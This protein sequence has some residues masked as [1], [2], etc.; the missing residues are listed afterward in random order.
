M[1]LAHGGPTGSP[2]APHLHPDVIAV[3][4]LV[5]GAYWLALTRLRPA[6]EPACTTR[7]ARL[8]VPGHSVRVLRVAGARRGRGLPVRRP[9]G[10]A[11]D[12]QP[13]PAP[14][15]HPGHTTVAVASRARPGDARLPSAGAPLGRGHVV[16]RGDRRHPPAFLRHRR[17]PIRALPLGP[18]SGA[19]P[20][21]SGAVVAAA[22]PSPRD[23][24]PV[25]A[26]APDRLRV[27]AVPGAVGR[28]LVTDLGPNRA[29]SDLRGIPPAVGDRRT[30]RPAVGGHD[31]GGGRGRSPAGLHGRRVPALVRRELRSP[32]PSMDRLGRVPADR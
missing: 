8:L 32:S 1:M 10:P 18:A 9:H 2:L 16:Q 23:A 17:R 6:G 22:R 30:R 28:R 15:V 11:F 20:G 19:G 3:V 14:A 24:P 27:P 5:A 7:Q 31:H 29:L 21:R 12:V 25:R 13:G 4:A 26:R